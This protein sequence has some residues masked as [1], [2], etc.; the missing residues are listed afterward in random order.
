MLRHAG[1]AEQDLYLVV[2]RDV[3]RRADHAVLVVR[4]EGRLL[5]LD[6]GTNRILDSDS[7]SDYRPILTF[8]GN[9]SW[10]HGYRREVEA[11]V[12]MAEAAPL[13]VDGQTATLAAAALP[14]VTVS[15]AF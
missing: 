12:Q 3:A 1:F 7:L 8:S 10:T 5:V 14:A 13:P 9:R 4:S 15:I 2:L 11:P 6:N